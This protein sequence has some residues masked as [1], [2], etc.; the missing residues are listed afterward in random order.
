MELVQPYRGDLWWGL[1]YLLLTNALTLWA[2]KLLNDGIALFDP[3]DTDTYTT[4]LHKYDLHQMGMT[5]A[6]G[7]HTSLWVLLGILVLIGIIAAAARVMSR[8]YLF[9]VGRDM[10]RDLRFTLFAHMGGLAPSILKQKNV[11]DLMSRLTN[12][13]GNVRLIAGFGVLNIANTVMV[14][15][16]T[17]PVMFGIDV[18]VSLGSLLVFPVIIVIAQI[19]SKNMFKRTRANQ[20]ELGKLNGLVQENLSGQAVVRAFAQEDSEIERF[21][22]AN[23]RLLQSSVDLAKIRILFFPITGM[24]ASLSLAVALYLS[25][26][27]VVDGRMNVGDVVEFNTRLMQLAWPTLALGFLM[28][29]YQRGKASIARLEEVLQMRPDVLDGPEQKP[30][31]GAISV[32]DLTVQYPSTTKPA[33]DKVSFTVAAGKTLGIVGKNAS[34]KSTLLRVLARLMPVDSNMVSFDGIDANQWHLSR[35]HKDLA[36]VPD[37][38][39]LFSASVRDNIAF[40]KP[41]ATDAEIAAVIQLADIAKDIQI[42]P[43][44]LNTM[45][46]ERG[47]TLS[48]GQRQ[49]IAL[50]R[51]LLV[52]PKILILDDSLSAVDAET[53][54]NIV[55]AL[56]QGFVFGTT[57][58]TKSNTDIK[59]PT[60]L[61]ISHRLSAVREADEI[62]SLDGGKIVE[63]GTH[64][65][66]LQKGGLY[67]DLWGREQLQQALASA[68]SEVKA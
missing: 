6:M 9:S 43:D 30:L 34:G 10:E 59:P 39:F 12:D 11:G 4:S 25:G 37:D 24:V 47:I 23:V 49:R 44:G 61:I 63:R 16:G 28:S 3:S 35:L 55:A 21:H 64:A 27:A 31:V 60:L 54:A 20:E 65:H 32:T 40:G 41:D 29:V 19:T 57:E 66:L 45:V 8:V 46:G 33:L 51:A 58:K 36:V 52:K 7:P 17:I 13:L 42:F 56:R 15:V 14:F 22:A 53:E 62:I 48:G 38:G 26:R 2:P 1:A 18:W 5:D 50:A 67:A 68:R